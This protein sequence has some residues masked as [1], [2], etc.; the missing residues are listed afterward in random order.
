M[1]EKYITVKTKLKGESYKALLRFALRKCA[2]FSLVYNPDLH[3]NEKAAKIRDVLKPFEL[4]S[5]ETS[6]WPGT[7]L[8]GG[9]ATVI[10]YRLDENSMTILAE[11][12][13]LYAWEGPDAPEDLAFYT[14]DEKCWMSSITHERDAFF[15]ADLVNLSEVRENFSGVQAFQDDSSEN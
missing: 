11:R 15:N 10:H 2:S 8:L 1:V 3:L 12:Q 13:S 4:R 9:K 6:A 14:K 7:V 5:E